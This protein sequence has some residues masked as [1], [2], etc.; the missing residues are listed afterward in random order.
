MEPG[1]AAARS[2][3]TLAR[4]VGLAHWA[5][6]VAR[7]M[8]SASATA[9]IRRHAAT[10][11]RARG[12]KQLLERAVPELLQ[13]AFAF[14]YNRAADAMQAFTTGSFPPRLL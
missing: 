5:T 11:H 9:P 14:A 10:V 3:S 4:G 2:A 6:V 8:D 12:S 1:L 7:L 13:R